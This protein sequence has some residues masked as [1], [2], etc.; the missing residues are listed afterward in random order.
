M[1]K[2][3]NHG[4]RKGI[5]DIWWNAFMVKDCRKW[6]N[7]DI[8]FCP[9]EKVEIPSELITWAEA[10]SI[11]NKLKNQDKDYIHNA[12]ICFYL[13][14]Y[15]FD[16]LHG[17]WNDYNKALEIIRHFAGIIS[18][19]FSTYKDFPTPLKAWN[20]YRM[21]AFG[22]WCTTQ[23]INVINNVRWSPDTID[24]CFK[25]IPK[26]S[27]VCL[28]VVASDLKHSENWAEYEHYLQM[29]I[30][31]LQPKIILIYGSARYKFFKALQ[32]QKI[33]VKSYQ[34]VRNRKKACAGDCL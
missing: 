22:F 8:P 3:Q 13:D 23:G 33:I 18:P 32:N 11:H 4:K 16:G 6:E 34:I 21:R 28:G 12:Y 9:T 19:D 7:G 24:I 5:R 31:E 20:T 1:N 27:V 25:G 30:Q 26:N 17:I 14:D 2:I 10:V 15:K 29:M